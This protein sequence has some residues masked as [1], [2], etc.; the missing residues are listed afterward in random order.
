MQTTLPGRTGA[1]SRRSGSAH[2]S[3]VNSAGP[4]IGYPVST[5]TVAASSRAP[6]SLSTAPTPAWPVGVAKRAIRTPRAYPGRSGPPT[7]ATIAGMTSQPSDR[8]P[9]VLLGGLAA[10]LVSAGVLPWLAGGSGAARGFA[11]PLLL[12]GLFAG[13]AVLRAVLA[14]PPP[15]AARPGTTDGRSAAG[16]TAAPGAGCAGCTC[17]VGV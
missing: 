15:R 9:L 12:G 13:Y 8:G 5:A 1:S 10:L 14:G 3:P 16:W 2:R 4:S 11:I 17:G 6:G 7:L